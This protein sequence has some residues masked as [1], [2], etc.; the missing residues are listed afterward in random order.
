MGLYKYCAQRRDAIRQV[1][2][3]YLEPFEAAISS[4]TEHEPDKDLSGFVRPATTKIATTDPNR[5]CRCRCRLELSSFA[6]ETSNAAAVAAAAAAG[7]AGCT[8][9]LA[10]PAV[11]NVQSHILAAHMR[12]QWG[13]S[14]D[15][16]DSTELASH[17]EGAAVRTAKHEPGDS[18]LLSKS[19]KFSNCWPLTLGCSILIWACAISPGQR[20]VLIVTALPQ[21]GA[22]GSAKCRRFDGV[23]ASLR[24][25]LLCAPQPG[26]PHFAA[27]GAGLAGLAAD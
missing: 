23:R 22:R 12:E 10:C 3:R 8:G 18:K 27:S 25:L 7:T 11:Y 15:L 21:P 13:L 20:V 17:G 14:C 1:Y 26:T 19:E 5:Q 4:I 2:L 16:V 9:E 24:L 6:S